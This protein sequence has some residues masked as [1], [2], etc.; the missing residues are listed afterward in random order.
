MASYLCRPSP[1]GLTY[2]W[3]AGLSSPLTWRCTVIGSSTWFD[4]GN[5]GSET[6]FVVLLSAE[7]EVW[8]VYTPARIIESEL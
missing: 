3:G 2:E 1:D 4:E 6:A 5:G 7:G 8:Y